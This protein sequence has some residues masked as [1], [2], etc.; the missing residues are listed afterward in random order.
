MRTE[1]WEIDYRSLLLTADQSDFSSIARYLDETLPYLWLDVYREAT[2]HLVNVLRVPDNGFTYIY[3]FYSEFEVKGVVQ[4]SPTIEDRMVGA[5]GYSQ[6]SVRRR[7]VARQRAWVG[8]TEKRFGKENDKG[9]FVAHT[10]GGGLELNVFIQC[11]AV[12]R[13]WSPKGK[14]YRSMEQFCL[15]HP[16]TFF[17][18]RPFYADCTCRPSLL[19]FGIL[20]ADGDLWIEHFEN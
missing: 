1:G 6:R 10:L 5:L 13:G 14:L 2:P 12:N 7:D 11:R 8:P 4:N 15:R 9:H 16:G 18:S 20:K 17:F 19:E 3:D